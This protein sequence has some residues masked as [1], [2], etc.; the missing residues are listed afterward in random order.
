MLIE[1]ATTKKHKHPHTPPCPVP[2][3]L[4][5]GPNIQGGCIHDPALRF[6]AAEIRHDTG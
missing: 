3:S 6:L 5:A 1:P 4:Y 2:L